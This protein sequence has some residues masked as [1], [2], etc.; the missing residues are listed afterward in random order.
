M[1]AS[2]LWLLSVVVAVGEWECVFCGSF[3][4]AD[5]VGVFGNNSNGHSASV[6][7]PQRVRRP[8]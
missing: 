3:K 1:F 5:A 4:I 7:W 2:W 6:E 8:E